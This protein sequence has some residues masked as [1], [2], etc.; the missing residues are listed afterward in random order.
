MSADTRSGRLYGVGVGPGDPELITV[1]AQR[2][3]R[4]AQVIAYPCARHGQSN[5]RSIVCSELIHGQIELPM[6]YPVTTEQTDHPGGYEVVIS[7]FYDDMAEQ[8]T[9]HRLDG[10]TLA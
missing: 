10:G 3:L 2:V 7:Q 4:Q 1:K 8:I 9:A 6:M 5:A